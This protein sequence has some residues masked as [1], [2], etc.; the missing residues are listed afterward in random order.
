M[1]IGSSRLRPPALGFPA[2]VYGDFASGP[3]CETE[4]GGPPTSRKIERGDLLLLD[5]SVVVDGYRGDFTNTFAVGGGPTPRQ[6]E[7]FAACI[8]APARWRGSPAARYSC[9]RGRRRRPRPV[10]CV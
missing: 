7:L 3:R 1:L 2:I 4:Q 9:P 10:C 8:G 5:F 6:R